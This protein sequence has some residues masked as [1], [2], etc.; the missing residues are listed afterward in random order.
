MSAG[1]QDRGLQALR[2]VREVRERDSRVGLGQALADLA[3]REAAA[4]LA[5]ERVAS[6]PPFEAG[7][8]ED[9]RRYQQLVGGLAEAARARGDL[10]RSGR[11]V[12]AE[13][14]RRWSQDRQALRSV[15]LLL[16]RRAEQRRAD[17]ARREAARL[18]ELA[19]QAWVRAR[20]EP[21][22]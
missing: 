5:W 8:A 12:V 9:F 1:A 22:R 17:L 19:A 13:A 16:E 3:E 15:E 11:T 6:T 18:D 10:V 7:D 14:R 21:A 20:Q 4:A 2:R